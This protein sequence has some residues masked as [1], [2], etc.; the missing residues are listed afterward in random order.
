MGALVQVFENAVFLFFTHPFD[1][2][3]AI[4][5]EGDRFKVTCISLQYV[6]LIR[7]DGAAVNVPCRSAHPH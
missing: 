4:V 6:K 3:D 2:G 7:M 5:F 1:V